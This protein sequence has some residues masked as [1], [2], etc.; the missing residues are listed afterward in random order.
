MHVSRR[1]GR[2]QC[3]SECLKAKG[4]A[5]RYY[6]EFFFTNTKEIKKWD[7][8]YRDDIWLNHDNTKPYIIAS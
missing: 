4:R 6:S 5:K 3:F 7:R 8:N 1:E 2:A